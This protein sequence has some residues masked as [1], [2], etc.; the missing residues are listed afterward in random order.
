VPDECVAELVAL[1]RDVGLGQPGVQDLIQR[2]QR[3]GVVQLRDLGHD[4]EQE[5]PV[6]AGGGVEQ[7]VGVGRQARPPAGQHLPDPLGDG[8]H[9]GVGP[10]RAVR[11]RLDRLGLQQMA[12]HLAGEE[13]VPASLP[14]DRVGQRV[15]HG[16]RGQRPEHAPQRVG[17]QAVEVKAGHLGLAAQGTRPAA[18]AA[19]PGHGRRDRA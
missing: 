1:G 7:A 16:R 9:G 5:R 8:P 3:G 10:E 14:L 17:G 6:E 4:R 18:S 15:R 13:R 12:Q 19:P 2:R 11:I